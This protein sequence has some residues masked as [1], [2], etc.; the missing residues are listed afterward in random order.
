MMTEDGRRTALRGERASALR[1]V[2]TT[3]TRTRCG[4]GAAE[5]TCWVQSSYIEELEEEDESDARG[6]EL[7]RAW[8]FVRIWKAIVRYRWY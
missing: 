3:A 6:V 7:D 2:P 1:P 4:T 8:V 5:G